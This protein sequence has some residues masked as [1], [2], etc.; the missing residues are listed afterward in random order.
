MK[1]PPTFGPARH[2]PF[3]LFLMETHSLAIDESDMRRLISFFSEPF[4]GYAPS[5]PL[6][7][8]PPPTGREDPPY[9]LQVLEHLKERQE[10]AP[11]EAPVECAIN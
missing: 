2:R 7:S 4:D 6:E 3:W 5:L 8:H 11:D 10:A 9:F 1:R